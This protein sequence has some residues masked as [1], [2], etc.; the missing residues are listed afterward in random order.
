MNR[1]RIKEIAHNKLTEA[2][3]LALANLLVKAGYSV[4]IGREKEGSKS[5]YRHFVE[6]WSD[7]ATGGETT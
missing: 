5:T 1:G 2:D 4:R 7:R 6:F 3:R